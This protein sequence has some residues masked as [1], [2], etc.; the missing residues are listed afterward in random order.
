MRVA[1]VDEKR[2]GGRDCD[3]RSDEWPCGLPASRY[4][5]PPVEAD[6]LED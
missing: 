2:R 4:P 3:H 5:C 1:T 6:S